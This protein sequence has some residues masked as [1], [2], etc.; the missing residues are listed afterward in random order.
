MLRITC[1]AQVVLPSPGGPPRSVRSPPRSPPVRSASNGSKP[2]GQTRGAADRP[3]RS[4]ASLSSSTLARVVQP[5]FT[6]SWKHAWSAGR[7]VFANRERRLQPPVLYGL[8]V[9]FRL[10][11]SRGRRL[12][13][14]AGP[15]LPL[16]LFLLWALF[17]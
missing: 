17:G 16:A 11:W 10:A 1:S 13:L 6:T 4:A 15:P 12:R 2:V 14:G 3:E 8:R 5:S 9:T 7:G